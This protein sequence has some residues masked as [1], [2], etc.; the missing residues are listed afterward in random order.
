MK[1]I[2]R[3]DN[4]VSV[5]LLPNDTVIT[6]DANQTVVGADPVLFYISDCNTSNTTVYENVTEPSE[7]SGWKYLYTEE[8]GWVLNQNWP[9]AEPELP[10]E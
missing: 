1:T 8:G 4:N 7:W 3:N 2:V 10:G 9:P 5:H 6:Q